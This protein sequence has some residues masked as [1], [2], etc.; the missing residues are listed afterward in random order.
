[1]LSRPL[2][3]R[4]TSAQFCFEPSQSETASRPNGLRADG[5]CPGCY[6]EVAMAFPRVRI[7]TAAFAVGRTIPGNWRL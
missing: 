3:S 2:S 7:R 5:A 4:V 6:Q 1:M